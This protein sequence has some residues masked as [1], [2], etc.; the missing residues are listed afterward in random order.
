MEG[1]TEAG[2]LYVFSVFYFSFNK[3]RLLGRSRPNEAGDKKEKQAAAP[4]E[5]WRKPSFKKSKK[6]GG[7]KKV[8]LIIN[9]KE[10]YKMFH[11]TKS[12][13][14]F[15]SQGARQFKHFWRSVGNEL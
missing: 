4:F 15:L 10:E 1:R 6:E 8:Q 2:S 9:D 3:C 11:A 7:E 5:M 12:P 13:L 14:F